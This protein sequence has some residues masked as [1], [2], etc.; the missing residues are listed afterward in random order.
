MVGAEAGLYL[1][2]VQLLAGAAVHLLELL[3]GP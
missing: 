3:G 2:V 1:A